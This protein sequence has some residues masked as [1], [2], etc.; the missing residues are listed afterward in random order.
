[1]HGFD[2]LM[3]FFVLIPLLRL[4]RSGFSVILKIRLLDADL[5]VGDNKGR[6][7]GEG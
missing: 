7:G 4:L 2:V 5:L 3:L 6:G 1:M